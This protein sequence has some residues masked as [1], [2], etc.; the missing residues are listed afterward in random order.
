M[1]DKTV[2]HME[3]ITKF[4]SFHSLNLKDF[5][6]SQYTSCVRGSMT[7]NNGIMGSGLDDWVYWHLY[8]NYS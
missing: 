1:F 7:N 8:Y 5:K 4:G 2:V 6:S 3:K